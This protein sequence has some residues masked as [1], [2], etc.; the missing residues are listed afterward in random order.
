MFFW[1]TRTFLSFISS[2]T[3]L[4]SGHTLWYYTLDP[5]FEVPAGMVA[6]F[7]AGSIDVSM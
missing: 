1:N 5:S 3:A 4:T 2:A 7:P 6:S